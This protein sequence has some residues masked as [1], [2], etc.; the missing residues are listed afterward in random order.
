M[1]EKGR[2]EER[3]S[4][5]GSTGMSV[6]KTTVD[7]L[8]KGYDIR[9]RPDFG[10][11]KDR[12]EHILSKDC[13]V[14]TMY[15][16]TEN[17]TQKMKEFLTHNYS[18]PLTFD[19]ACPPVIVGMSINIASIDSISEVNMDYTITMY[20]Q[21]S[22]RDKRLAYGEL[23]LN[24]TLDNRV[25]DQLWL[26]DTYF[27][28]DKKSFLHGVTVKNRMIRLHP[29]GTVL[30]GLR[31]TTT[32][33]CM[34]DLR[35]YPLD[36]QN[37]TLEIESYGYTTDDIVFFWQGGD[38]AVTGVDKLELPQFSIVDIRLVSREVRFTTG[39]YPR[40]S[41]SFRIKRNIGYFIL[42]TYMPS[43]LITILSWVS[44][45]INYDASAAR[46]AL[47][48]TTVLTM[49][50]I[51]THLRETLPKIPY[52]KAIDVYLMGCFVFVFLALLEYAF[53]NYVFFG[54]GPA[55]QK[56]IN[57]RLNKANN[58]RTRYEEKRLREQ[59]DAYGN[60]LLTTL[61]MNNEVMPSDVGSSVSD[62]R[63][64]VM[65]FDSSGVQFR[66]PMAPRDGFSHH[67]LDRSAM[68]S[69]ANCRLR[70]RSSKLKLKI[71]NLSD[72]STIDKWSRV[73]FPITFGFFNLIYWLYYVN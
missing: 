15:R 26:P 68:R 22:W 69:R 52:V 43:I 4:S 44:F 72:V 58:E 56:K 73:I 33:A 29:D 48:V 40:L 10:G 47:G 12:K 20:F 30:Y 71:P 39:S 28:N 61:E 17:K 65:S 5:T 1:G 66:K 18:T 36:E 55:Q 64:S 21:Q 9:L 25:A 34:M 37:C 13:K 24:L 35:R 50:T 41:L 16:S 59:V 27:L 2:E 51:N 11:R 67:S 53:V 31:I 46:V 23:N 19:K 54:R 7:K 8:L 6:A 57:E 63:N 42:Q 49:T 3:S 45:W 60:I 32:A 70:R 62:S 38:N 14:T